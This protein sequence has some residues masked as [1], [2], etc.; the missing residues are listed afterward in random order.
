MTRYV[1]EPINSLV[2][3]V[4]S[5]GDKVTDAVVNYK[6]YWYDD[7]EEAFVVV[8]SGLMTHTGDGLY[9]VN[10]TPQDE[11]EHTFYAYST[12]PKFHES[13]TYEVKYALNLVAIDACT[14]LIS[15]T[16]L[17]NTNVQTLLTYG[18]SYSKGVDRTYW[19]DLSALTQQATIRRW[20]MIGNDQRLVEKLV[21]PDDF[22]SEVNGVEMNIPC[23]SGTGVV[24]IQSTVAEGASRTIPIREMYRRIIMT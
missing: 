15:L 9:F 2:Q 21:Y 20:I 5:N 8:D 24:T 7:D 3:V 13:Y 18:Y 12:N 1:D 17:S 11:G 14:I 23:I 10:W 22:P 19:F 6:V 16:L 4:D